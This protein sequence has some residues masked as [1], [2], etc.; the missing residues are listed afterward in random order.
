[1]GIALDYTTRIAPAALTGA[2]VT[3]VL[4]Y[5]SWPHRWGGVTHAGINP[6]VI[7]AREFDELVD[8]GLGVTLNWEYDAQDWMSG[9]TGARAH[10]AEAVRQA[11]DL[12]YPSGCTIIGSA[13]FDM[14]R[15]QWDTAGRHYAAA[16]R[17]EIWAG[18][19]YAGVYGPCDVLAWCRDETGLGVFWQA[20]MSTAWSAGRN[21]KP[22]PGAHIRQRGHLAVA[23][24]DADWNEIIIPDWGQHRALSSEGTTDVYLSDQISGTATADG[25]GPRTVDQVLGDLWRNMLPSVA[26]TN[27]L[28]LQIATDAH[29]AATRTLP[30]AMSAAD[31]EAIIAGVIAALPDPPT[32]AE[33]A[34]ELATRI[35]NG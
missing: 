16:W 1:M 33:I 21:A 6:K 34:E 13:D 31:R 22:W 8:A 3:D 32:A 12:G 30:V 23:G 2:G 25:H 19:Y 18:G 10:A 14:S 4:R 28:P 7:Q 26:W 11:R 27:G 5:L 17:A 24:V 35:G 9:A 15:A 20:G 29:T